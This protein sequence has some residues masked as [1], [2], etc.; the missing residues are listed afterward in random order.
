MIHPRMRIVLDVL[1]Y[2][3]LALG[4][5]VILVPLVW[6]LSTSLKTDAQIF[7]FPP[8]WIPDP[9]MWS[10]YKS[11]MVDYGLPFARFFLNSGLI[12]VLSTIGALI[13]SSVV[14]FAFS[15]LSWQG[16]DAL[17]FLVIVT[18]MIPREVVLVPEFILFKS[19]GWIDTFLPLIVPAFF[20]HPFYIFILRQYMMGITPEMDQAARI[21]GCGTWR[22]YWN[23]IMPQCRLV[24]ITVV[25]FSIQSNWNEFIGPLVYLNSMKNFTVSIGLS[26]FS[27][28]YGTEW[29][30]L[31]AASLLVM[32]PILILFAVAQRHFIQGI[33]ITGIK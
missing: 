22:V 13:S 16:R 15:R 29:G 4:A 3:I 24:L 25:I 10:N 5:C 23:I 17:F 21:D 26:M 27:G 11:S 7:K 31:M 19:L 28:Q 32:L 14:A 30:L 9:F 1:T 8:E 20:G 6:M 2:V 12:T 33:V 18:M